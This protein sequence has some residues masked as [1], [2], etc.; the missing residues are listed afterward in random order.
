[1]LNE[2]KTSRPRSR[3]EPR[4]RGQVFEAAVKGHAD[5]T[6]RYFLIRT[7]G[8]NAKNMTAMTLWSGWQH[9]KHCH[10]YCYYYIN[11]FVSHIRVYNHVFVMNVATMQP[12]NECN[13]YYFASQTILFEAKLT[14]PRPGRH[15]MLEAEANLSRSRPRPKFCLQASLASRP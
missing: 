5:A 2:A 1:M 8:D 7:H 11:E 9:Y 6:C 13:Q 12:R 15:Q 14:R 4:G 10:G 3:P